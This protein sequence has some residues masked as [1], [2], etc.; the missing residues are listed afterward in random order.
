MAA[1]GLWALLARHPPASPLLLGKG[2]QVTRDRLRADAE[3]AAAEL[4]GRVPPGATVVVSAPGPVELATW[5]L[6]LNRLGASVSLADPRSTPRELDRLIAH[7]RPVAL[8]AGSEVPPPTAAAGPPRPLAGGLF[9]PLAGPGAPAAGGRAAVHLY[10]SGTEGRLKGAVRGEVGL[11]AEAR[12]ITSMLGLEPGDRILCPVPLGHAFGFG[13]ALLAGLASGAAVVT[14]QPQT[15]RQLAGWVERLGVTI[16]IG[17]PAQYDLWSSAPPA[18]PAPDP[19][20]L[21]ISSGAYLAPEIARA[22]ETAWGRRLCQQYGMSECGPVTL[23]LEA[24][25][26]PACVG[27]P[28]PGV[29]LRIAD[30]DPD[31]WGEVVVASPYAASGY[32]GGLERELEPDPFTADG[33]RI[34]DRGRLDGRGRLHLAGRRSE[35]IN[36]H[37][38]K[39]D[40]GEVEGVLREHPGVRE[41]V[42][43]GVE[44]SRGDQWIAAW[45]VGE[46]S[47]S[48]PALHRL[49]RQRLAT[50]KEPRRILFIDAIPR[51]RTGKPRR[52]LLVE[53]LRRAGEAREPAIAAGRRRA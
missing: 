14:A 18:R 43:A 42:V 51:T 29:R 45:V 9:H 8:L 5:L 34:G 25:A 21:C 37:G 7:E 49:C 22:F 23:D 15:G 35:M 38:R 50:Y 3:A 41:A 46:P 11:V 13:M 2:F 33:I 20:R 27:L 10:T 30:P 31:G 26:D 17:V 24:S 44:T 4:A 47:L 40:P 36:V 48:E 39:V 6:A 16:L 19:L 28:Y 53:S 52:D 32:V 12:G 1:A